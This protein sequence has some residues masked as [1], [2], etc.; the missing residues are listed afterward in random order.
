[1][2]TIYILVRERMVKLKLNLILFA[3]SILILI[4][5]IIYGN[6]SKML[7]TIEKFDL[8]SVVILLALAVL[9][10]AFRFLRFKLLLDT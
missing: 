8:T 4:A 9:G 3:I 1:M 7:E 10:L 6:P 2:F 5:L